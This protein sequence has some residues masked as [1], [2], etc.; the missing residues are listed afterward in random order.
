MMIKITN[1]FQW[2]VPNFYHTDNKIIILSSIKVKI[3]FS[4]PVDAAMGLRGFAFLLTF[5]VISINSDGQRQFD[6]I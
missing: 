6:S 3:E 1:Q 2:W 4:P 5:K